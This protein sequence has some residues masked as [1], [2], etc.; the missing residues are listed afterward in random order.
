VAAEKPEY[1]QAREMMDKRAATG[2]P[3]RE[4][5]AAAGISPKTVE[6]RIE[7]YSE[8]VRRYALLGGSA[9]GGNAR[10]TRAAS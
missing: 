2:R 4:L 1:A 10:G 6:K 3:I 9:A 7:R 5:A 8:A